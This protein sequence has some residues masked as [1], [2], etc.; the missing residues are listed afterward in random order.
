M[1]AAHTLLTLVCALSA[2]GC[3]TLRSSENARVGSPKIY[4]GTRLDLAAMQSDEPTLR[5]FARYGIEPPAHP[6]ADMAFSLVGDT[7]M[8]PFAA[9]YLV[10]EPFVGRR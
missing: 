3:A 7:L 1:K 10:T 8:L 2:T 4:A 6:E 9:W 5:E